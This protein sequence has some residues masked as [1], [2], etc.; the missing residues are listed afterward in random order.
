M[1]NAESVRGFLV[2]DFAQF[3]EHGLG[4]IWLGDEMSDA[5]F[6]DLG[7]IFVKCESA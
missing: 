4:G 6:G 5:G 2:E 1:N 3:V 7:K